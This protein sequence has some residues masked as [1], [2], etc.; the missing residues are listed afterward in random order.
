M[1]RDVK[2]FQKQ[3][4][5]INPNAGSSV[6]LIF[7]FTFPLDSQPMGQT[8]TTQG[9]ESEGLICTEQKL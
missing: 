6:L 7:L 5:Q 2:A 3:M 1:S 9:T 8:S 4:F